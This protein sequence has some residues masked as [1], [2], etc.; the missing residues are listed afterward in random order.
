[1]LVTGGG[2]TDDGT[3]WHDAPKDFLVPVLRALRR[4]MP[5]YV[6]NKS[7]TAPRPAMQIPGKNEIAA[8]MPGP[9]GLGFGS[10]MPI[11]DNRTMISNGPEPNTKMATPIYRIDLPIRN[12]FG[13]QNGSTF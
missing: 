9:T 6:S 1:M 2:V 3:A 7:I 4:L 13:T 11:F 5:A 12:S 8:N 10:P